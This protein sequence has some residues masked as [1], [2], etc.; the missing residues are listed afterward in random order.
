[1]GFVMLTAIPDFVFGLL[2]PEDI[3]GTPEQPSPELSG[4]SKFGL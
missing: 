1:M 2:A 3:L 4:P